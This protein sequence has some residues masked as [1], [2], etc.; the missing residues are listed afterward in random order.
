MHLGD[1]IVLAN[2]GCVKLTVKAASGV[3]LNGTSEGFEILTG[4]YKRG[5]LIKVAANTYELY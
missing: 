4:P 2:G 1:Q 5:V 3:T